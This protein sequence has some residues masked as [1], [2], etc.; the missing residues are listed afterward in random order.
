MLGRATR[1]LREAIALDGEMAAAHAALGE[2]FDVQ[3]RP[4]EARRSLE[5]ALRKDPTLKH[6]Y[7]MLGFL[8]LNRQDLAAA[9]ENFQALTL[10]YPDEATG[11]YG[12][13]L[14]DAEEKDRA[15]ARERLRKALDVQPGFDQARQLLE[16]IDRQSP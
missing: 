13:A 16:L 5:V 3:D 8:A 11:Y 12:L 9:R 15:L 14:L 10:R 4:D 2:I 1:L 7:A 6:P